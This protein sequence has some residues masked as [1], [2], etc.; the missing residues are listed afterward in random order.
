[1]NGHDHR[2][3]SVA[4]ARREESSVDRHAVGRRPTHQPH[5]RERAILDD[6]VV[7]VGEARPSADGWVEPGQLRWHAVGLVARDHG[8]VAHDVDGR[9]RQVWPDERVALP[10]LLAATVE[11][12]VPD[13]RARAGIPGVP[14]PVVGDPGNTTDRFEPGPGVGRGA[15]GQVD[16]GHA[17]DE[18]ARIAGIA[19]D[20]R[21]VPGVWG[22]DDPFERALPL[23]QDPGRPRARIDR[24]QPS[25]IP[26]VPRR[27]VRD[28]PDQR[29]AAVP[30]DLPDALPARPD[31]FDLARGHID[32]EQPPPRVARTPHPWRDPVRSRDRARGPVECIRARIR[33]KHEQPRTVGRPSHALGRTM[34]R[35]DQPRLVIERHHVRQLMPRCDPIREERESRTIWRPRRGVPLGQADRRLLDATQPQVAREVPPDVIDRRQ[36]RERERPAVRRHRE[37]GR[38][39]GVQQRLVEQPPPVV[40]SVGHRTLPRIVHGRHRRARQGPGLAADH[41][42]IRGPSR[43]SAAGAKH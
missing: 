21:H 18:Q 27:V 17:P 11:P 31:L 12:Q 34:E 2:P 16:D 1:M 25:P 5:V 28:Q 32:H 19:L 39:P 7:E 15:V 13:G 4:V 36:Q 10:T 43:G 29:P 22:E 38:R 42:A 33:G 41:P 40:L 9:L 20:D 3:R 35:R 37:L 8:P 23:V 24:R 30:V 6:R 14:Q 26:A